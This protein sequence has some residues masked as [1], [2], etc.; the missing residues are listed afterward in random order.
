MRNL[1]P[2]IETFAFDVAG[3]HSPASDPEL[4]HTVYRAPAKR[5]RIW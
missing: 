1:M 5:V 4:G 3:M 2:A